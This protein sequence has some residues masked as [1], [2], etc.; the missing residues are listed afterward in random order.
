MD[1]IREMQQRT[2]NSLEKKKKK[3]QKNK[4]KTKHQH[5]HYLHTGNKVRSV[6]CPVLDTS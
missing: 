3:E 5:Q 6:T 1:E 2:I 4:Q